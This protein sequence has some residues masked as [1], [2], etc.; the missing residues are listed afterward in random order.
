M[1]REQHGEYDDLHTVGGIKAIQK[2][3]LIFQV[4]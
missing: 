2:K 3:K 1:Y 4:S